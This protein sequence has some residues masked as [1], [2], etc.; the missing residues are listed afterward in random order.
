[1][2]DAITKLVKRHRA[3][4]EFHRRIYELGQ[5]NDAS[6]ATL[7]LCSELRI[8]SGPES[9]ALCTLITS[10]RADWHQPPMD[11]RKPI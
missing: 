10:A 7:S 11:R 3:I 1:L 9:S 8:V 6:G 4:H 5:R 2:L